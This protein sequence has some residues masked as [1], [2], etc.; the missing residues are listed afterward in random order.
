MSL[1]LKLLNKVK[2]FFKFFKK[3]SVLSRPFTVV[4]MFEIVQVYMWEEE[5]TIS[6]KMR[7]P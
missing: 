4:A 7:Y 5:N 2:L 1:K 3:N 6:L